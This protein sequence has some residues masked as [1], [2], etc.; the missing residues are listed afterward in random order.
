M[1]KADFFQRALPWTEIILRERN[2][3]ND[4]NTGMSGRASVM[5]VFL[6]LSSLVFSFWQPLALAA[7]G[8]MALMLLI[9][10]SPL[11]RF[12]LWKR[13]VRFTHNRSHGTGSIFSIAELYLP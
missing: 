1:L 4:L 7:A 5:L 3:I 13:G 9:L 11:Y 10:N 12:F 8:V 2:C 6:L